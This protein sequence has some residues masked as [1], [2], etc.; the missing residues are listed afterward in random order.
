[1]DTA[2]DNNSVNYHLTILRMMVNELPEGTASL[3]NDQ[4]NKLCNA[5]IADLQSSRDIWLKLKETM[6]KELIDITTN[7]NYMQFDLEAT[8]RERDEYKSR[9]EGD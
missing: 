1:M 7:V 6:S 9:I 5:F 8:R 4:I 3:I 2:S